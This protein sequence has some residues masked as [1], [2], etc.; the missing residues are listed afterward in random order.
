MVPAQSP[1]QAQK[2]KTTATATTATTTLLHRDAAADPTLYLLH[3]A[4]VLGLASGTNH[5]TSSLPLLSADQA[6]AFLQRVA[7]ESFA[8]GSSSSTASSHTAGYLRNVHG[9]IRSPLWSAAASTSPDAAPRNTLAEA[10]ECLPVHWRLHHPI[11]TRCASLQVPGLTASSSTRR[12]R[13]HQAAAAAMQCLFCLGD[14]AARGSRQRRRGLKSK[15]ETG[16]CMSLAEQDTQQRSK[17]KFESVRQRKRQRRGKAGVITTVSSQK[18]A[19]E[20]NEVLRGSGSKKEKK[21]TST[22]SARGERSSFANDVEPGHPQARVKLTTPKKAERLE[23]PTPPSQIQP[24][25]RPPSTQTPTPTP[26]PTPAATSGSKRSHES[27]EVRETGSIGNKKAKNTAAV[28]NYTSGSAGRASGGSHK[29]ALRAMLAQQKGA[30]RGK[31]GRGGDDTAN[32][33]AKKGSGGTHA[34]GSAQSGGTGA[35]AGG[36]GLRDFLAGL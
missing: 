12:Q 36:G 6:A 11:C 9:R 28:T 3:S 33:G 32:G 2:R 23:G 8:P 29:D 16:L 18:P 7:Q 35:S 14:V 5:T 1:R 10:V 13:R 15:A 19:P 20:L 27:Q 24:Q 17:S 34:D 31:K 30:R 26:T 25:P 4:A 22:P 21:P